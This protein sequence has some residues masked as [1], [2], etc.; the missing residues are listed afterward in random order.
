MKWKADDSTAAVY[1]VLLPGFVQKCMLHSTV[2]TI[3]FFFSSGIPLYSQWSIHTVVRTQLGRKDVLSNQRDQIPL[4]TFQH[5]GMSLLCAYEHHF[6]LLRSCYRYISTGFLIS[7][8]CHV[9]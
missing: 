2:N 5:R 7:E 6:Q 8:A 4:K 9:M 1:R 3:E